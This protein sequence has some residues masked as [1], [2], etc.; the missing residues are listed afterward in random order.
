MH[1]AAL[2]GLRMV[3]NKLIEEEEEA[4]HNKGAHKS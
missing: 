4:H 3:G 1:Q 2:Q